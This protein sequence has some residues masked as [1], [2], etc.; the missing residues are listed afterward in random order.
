MHLKPISLLPF[1]PAAVFAIAAFGVPAAF[2]HGHGDEAAEQGEATVYTCPMHPEVQ[3]DK[4]G[5]CPKC[6]MNLAP[7]GG[8]MEGMHGDMDHGGMEGMHGDMDHGGMEGMHGDGGHMKHMADVR[9][10]LQAKLGAAYDKPVPGL[11]KADR[12]RGERIF[13]ERCATCHGSGGA[14]DGPAAAG[15]NPKPADLTDPEHARYYSD[16]GRIEIIRNGIP[17]TG[18]A[19]FGS[20]LDDAELLAVYAYVASLREGGAGHHH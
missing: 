10:A 13:A 7:A 18:M 11:D 12:E 8:G 15:L 19:G 3:S 4:P 14:G 9:A 17:G 20:Q 2:A 6:G 1:A 16:A 5:S